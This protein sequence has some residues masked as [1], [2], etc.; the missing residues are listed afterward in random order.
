V[1]RGELVTIA[2]QGDLGKPRP[3]L[4]IQANEFSE[5]VS[6]TILPVTSHLVDAPLL[7]V[8]LSPDQESGLTKESQVMIDKII[9]VKRAKIGQRIGRVSAEKLLQ[10]ERSLALF[11]G[12]A[13]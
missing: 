6:V 5:T 9:T 1:K 8:P 13:S 10:V 7:R 4:I 3:A 11:L 2:L 12:I